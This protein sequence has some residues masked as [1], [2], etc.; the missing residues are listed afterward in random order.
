MTLAPATI[1]ALASYAWPGNV[2]EL[3]NAIERAVI[4]ASSDVITPDL[5]PEEIRERAPA[6]IEEGDDDDSLDT[7]ERRHLASVLRRYPTLEA[8]A[9]ALKIDPS[10]LYRK[11]ERYGLR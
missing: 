6:K 7:A 5:L 1:E 4:L 8:A 9:K 10:T 3:V 11:R 2:R